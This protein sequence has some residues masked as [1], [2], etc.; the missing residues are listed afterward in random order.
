MPEVAGPLGHR[1]VA[2][3]LFNDGAWAILEQENQT[4]IV[5]PGDMVDGNRI[6]AI[7]PDSIFVTDAQGRRW[8]VNLRS[9]AP[10]GGEAAAGTIPAMPEAPPAAGE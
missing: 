1:R 2:G 6:T 9:L 3:L 5:K 8:Q 10:G 7:G 4:F